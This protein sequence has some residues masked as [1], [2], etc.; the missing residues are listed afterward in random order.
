MFTRRN[1][2]AVLA[3][4]AAA[5]CWAAGRRQ[6]SHPGLD[7]VIDISHSTRVKDFRLARHYSRVLA[8]IHKASEGGDWVDPLYA[9]RRTEAEGA[10]L[11]WGAYHFGTREYSGAAQAALFLRTAKPGPATL[12]ALDLEY[13]E[14][15]PANTMGIRQAEDFVRAVAAATGRRPLIYT[16]AAWADNEPVGARQ[17]RLGGRVTEDSILA[18]CPLWIADYRVRPELP[19]AWR[20]KGWHFWQYAGDTRDGGLRGAMARK[21][22]GIESCDRNYFRGDETTLRKFWTAREMPHKTRKA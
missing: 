17:Q 21:V 20:G 19:S 14:Q 12:L 15:N 1:L 8:V 11:L 2:L 22:A 6:A 3:G 16:T 7:A 5:P 9:R 18:Q 4:L 13:N 10:G